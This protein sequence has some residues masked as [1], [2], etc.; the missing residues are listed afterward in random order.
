MIPY[1]LTRSNRRTIA[2]HIRDGQLEVRAPLRTPTHEIERFITQKSGWIAGKLRKS[3]EQFAQR[4][5]FALTYGDN[6][7][8]RGK[9]FPITAGDGS[10]IG[11]DGGC[12]YMPPNLTSSE[13]KAV[14][15]K[16]YRLLAKQYIPERVRIIAADM[17]VAPSS[18]KI[19]SAKTCWGSCSGKKSLNFS[20]LLIMADDA[21]ID[22]VVVHELAHITEMNH[23]AKFWTVVAATMP[24]YLE[25]KAALKRLQQRLSTENWS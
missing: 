22:Y 10:R 15:I 4:E 2:L 13:I 21:V 6:I 23:S 19:N 9:A 25:H 17:G 14:C 18:V 5:A 7:L 1:T 20:W 24:D 3:S 8:C 16:I 11:F 12:F